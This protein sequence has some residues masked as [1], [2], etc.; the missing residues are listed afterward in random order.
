MRAVPLLCVALLVVST[1]SGT[2]EAQRRRRTPE[3]T[4]QAIS[5]SGTLVVTV[6]QEGAEV[7]VDEQLVG[8]S[9]IAPQTLPVGSHTVR[10]RMPG[11]GEYSDV[12]TVEP[13]GLADM[14][15][16]LFA[17]SEALSITTTP[18]GAHVFVDGNFMGETPVEVDLADG[19]HSIRVTL[20]GYEEVVREVTA[21]SGHHQEL[22]LA[23]AAIPEDQLR[24]SEWYEEPVL[25]IAVGGGVVAAVVIAVVVVV[26][27][28]G[29]GGSQIDA[30]CAQTG[31]CV[32]VDTPFLLGTTF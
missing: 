28:Q 16:E 22:A 32:R 2:A 4:P 27:T 29:S 13:G 17:L 12:I 6:V 9:P 1:L 23:M 5:S 14:P 8:T 30:F 20:H 11:F 18:P 31:G 26:T 24:G 21:E 25:W 10:V 7:Y 19:A 15:V 3:P